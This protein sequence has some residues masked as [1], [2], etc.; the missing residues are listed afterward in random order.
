MKIPLVLISGLLSNEYLWRYQVD[1]LRDIASIYLFSPT[2]NTPQKMVKYILEASP[3]NFAL[4][5]HSMGG[6]LCLEIIRAAGSRVSKLCLLNTTSR[7]D[8]KEKI[9]KRRALIKKAKEGYFEEIVEMIAE[10]FVFNSLVKNDVKKMFLKV[11]KEAFINQQ[12]AMLAREETQSVLA[13]IDCP[14]WV[15]H[16]AHD[17]NFSLEEQKEIVEKVRNAKLTVIDNAGHMSPLE[18]PQMVAD[19]LQ[20]WVLC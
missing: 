13:V 19:L 15:I 12:E 9:E 18:A 5:G 6:W 16:S 10:S 4:A 11:G 2:Q 17:N 20:R 8:S 7:N 3:P 14:T 1:Q